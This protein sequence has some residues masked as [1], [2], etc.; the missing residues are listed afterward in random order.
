MNIKEVRLLTIIQFVIIL[1]VLVYLICRDTGLKGLQTQEYIPSSSEL[2][3]QIS[4]GTIGSRNNLLG[5]NYL[6][7]WLYSIKRNAYIQFILDKRDGKIYENPDTLSDIS[8]ESL[9]KSQVVPHQCRIL[10]NGYVYSFDKQVWLKASYGKWSFDKKNQTLQITCNEEI[11]TDE[12]IITSEHE[13][14]VMVNLT[15]N[16]ITY[17]I[18]PTNWNLYKFQKSS[19]PQRDNTSAISTVL[20]VGTKVPFTIP[21][22]LE[23][24]HLPLTDRDF[25][26]YVNDGDSLPISPLPHNVSTSG[27]GASNLRR[28]MTAL[29]FEYAGASGGDAKW[30]LKTCFNK[31]NYFVDGTCVN[32][33]DNDGASD[34]NKFPERMKNIFDIFY[35]VL[36]KEED[37][38]L[39]D[40]DDNRTLSKRKNIILI[41]FNS[42]YVVHIT[43]DKLENYKLSKMKACHYKNVEDTFYLKKRGLRWLLMQD[44]RLN[45]HKSNGQQQKY[46][47]SLYDPRNYLDR[48]LRKTVTNPMPILIFKDTIYPMNSSIVEHIVMKVPGQAVKIL[49]SKQ[50]I[51][52]KTHTNIDQR[53]V[54]LIDNQ[55]ML[56]HLR[57]VEVTIEGAKTYHFTNPKDLSLSDY[58][59]K[60]PAIY[61][62]YVNEILLDL[63][64]PTQWLKQIVPANVQKSMRFI[65]RKFYEALDETVEDF[66][67]VE[68]I[69]EIIHAESRIDS[70]DKHLVSVL[71]TE[72]SYISILDLY[73]LK[74]IPK[75][76]IQIS[77]F[78]T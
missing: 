40:E 27:G 76:K 1:L 22:Y 51:E 70:K 16:N 78:V 64:I 55:Q 3:K 44:D 30:Q 20:S 69:T 50:D 17:G 61:A 10:S 58:L 25:N 67:F 47:A 63:C 71:P 53:R 6:V 28:D 14:R 4:R 65:G 72:F 45:V 31:N 33:D 57:R 26:E 21:R 37:D 75:R 35:P 23:Y 77:T 73:D 41:M 19:F 7:Y 54:F 68:S 9:V 39:K 48:R 56:P 52:I 5:D 8:R 43:D 46:L 29:Y 34:H 18:D 36:T 66:I 32:F 2:I 74:D 42:N 13:L 11:L 24:L 62:T 59:K 15:V 60:G 12:R 38:T 49:Q